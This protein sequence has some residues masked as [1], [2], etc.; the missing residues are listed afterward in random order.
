MRASL[1][2]ICRKHAGNLA[3]HAL[4]V[5]VLAAT[6]LTLGAP[7]AAAARL[8]AP[9]GIHLVHA[10]SLRGY[11]PRTAAKPDAR[12]TA[13]VTVPATHTVVSGDTL[14]GIAASYLGGA[15]EW[16]GL[17]AANSLTDCDLI[18]VGQGI[19]LATATV[20]VATAPARP[21]Y[22][23]PV[24]HAP[25]YRSTYV[26]PTH[27]VN[28]S[29]SYGRVNPESYS[30]FQACVVSHESGGNSQVMNASGHYGLYQFDL[31]T[32]ESGGGSAAEFGHASV[33][34]QNRVFA[35]VYAARGTNPWAPYDGC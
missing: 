18:Y 28:T 23:A 31:R 27:H 14:S 30:G 2:K 4:S 5:T 9:P 19:R 29:G 13:A 7:V 33:A 26:A 3:T 32:W 20:S 8:Q 25:T 1:G 15:T 17:C 34:E 16:R 12:L 35:N 10:P 11:H 22:Q 21:T 6:A 24:Y